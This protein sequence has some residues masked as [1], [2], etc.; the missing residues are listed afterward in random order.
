MAIPY[1]N[2]IILESYAKKMELAILTENLSKFYNVS[3]HYTK[4]DYK[5]DSNPSLAALWIVKIE[6]KSAIFGWKSKFFGKA[7]N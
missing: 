5:K 7:L 4:F 1:K 3:Q 2:K 6:Q